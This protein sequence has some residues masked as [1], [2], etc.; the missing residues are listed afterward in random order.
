MSNQKPE[1]NID[2]N[3][4]IETANTGDEL[5]K[6]K[7]ITDECINCHLEI[8]STGTYTNY[9][10]MESFG[11]GPSE[12]VS[13]KSYRWV[14]EA[15]RISKCATGPNYAAGTKMPPQENF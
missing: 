8:V 14:H 11:E 12:S 3:K 5:Q 9:R 10:K 15:T 13:R 1:L 2:I 6:G 7:G 4:L